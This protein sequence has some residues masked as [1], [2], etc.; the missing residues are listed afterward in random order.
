[1]AYKPSAKVT[2]TEARS[3]EFIMNR[4]FAYLLI[5][6]TTIVMPATTH[7]Q[8][9]N[10]SVLMLPE[11]IAF[12][13]LTG[14]PQRAVLFGDPTK[15]GMFVERVKF[16]PGMKIM[17]HYHPD[18]PRTVMVVSGTLYFG[19]GEQWD[20]SKFKPYPTGTLFSEPAKTPHYAWAKDGEVIIQI[21]SI[22][23]SGTVPI[24]QKV[25]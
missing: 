11:Q 7:A 22:G 20:E 14:A 18:E 8:S 25:Q 10:P 24:A 9:T 23:P 17:P 15:S 2:R 21:T 19:L 16:A 4:R 1:M 5:A 12:K 13:G 6:V 3:E